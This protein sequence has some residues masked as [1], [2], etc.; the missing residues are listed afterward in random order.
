MRARGRLRLGGLRGSRGRGRGRARVGAHEDEDKDG[1]LLLVR[2]EP[3]IQ[4]VSQYA[5]LY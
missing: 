2:S 4:P 3:G 1:R 5:G